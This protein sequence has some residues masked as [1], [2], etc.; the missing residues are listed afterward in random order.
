VPEARTTNGRDP[1]VAAGVFGLLFAIFLVR[2]FVDTPG[3]SLTFLAVFPIVLAGFWLGRTLAVVCAVLATALSIIVPLINP[4]TS[5]STSAQVVGAIG[6]GAVFIG[7]ALVVSTLIDREVALRQQLA[8]AEREMRELE[9]L[10]GALTSPDLPAVDGLEIATA[11]T[12]AEGLAAGDFFL[13]ARSIDGAV[14]VVLGDAV[15]HGL[16]AARRAAYVRTTIALYAQYTSDPIAILRLANTAVTERDPGTEYVTALCAVFSPGS[17]TVTWA[18]AGHPAPWDLDRGVPLG[19]VRNSLP[20]G[21]EPTLDGEVMTTTLPPGG[22]VLLYTDGL[23]EARTARDVARHE[24]FG[25]DAARD[26]LLALNGAGPDAIVAGLNA[27]AVRHAHGAM[28]DD[29]CIVAVRLDAVVAQPHA[30]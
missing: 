16:E 21:I 13:V 25:E 6:R 12:P 23:P 15:G 11:Y 26:T 20:L 5:I 30:A 4:S 10:R 18:S 17:G 3:L 28:A 24:L 1:R 14:I 22:G 7:L 27:A 19:S 2:A 9:S 8:D 29:L